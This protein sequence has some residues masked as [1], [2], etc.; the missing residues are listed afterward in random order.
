MPLYVK[1]EE[2]ARLKN[3][4][5]SAKRQSN[6]IRKQGPGSQTPPEKREKIVQLYKQY[7]S[8]GYVRKYAPAS[9]GVVKAV[10][11]DAGMI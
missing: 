5:A 3:R 6:A 10:L 7:P 2:M 4:L 9:D 1:P 11:G 8:F